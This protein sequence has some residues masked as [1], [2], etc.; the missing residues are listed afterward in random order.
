MQLA[1]FPGA[2]R[3]LLLRHLSLQTKRGISISATIHCPPP[4][5]FKLFSSVIILQQGHVVYF[6]LN[7]AVCE[8]YFCTYE[9]GLCCLGSEPDHGAVHGLPEHIVHVCLSTPAVCRR[10]PMHAQQ[11]K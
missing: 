10:M 5:T 11:L 1:G 6:G 3:E 7:G 2:A 9:V 4:H 8:D